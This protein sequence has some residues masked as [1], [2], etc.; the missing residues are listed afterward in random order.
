MYG[1]KFGPKSQYIITLRFLQGIA[2][3]QGASECT[4]NT[5]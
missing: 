4:T 5:T 3:K 2:S 1:T